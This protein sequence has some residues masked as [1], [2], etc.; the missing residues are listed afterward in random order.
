M[1]FSFN[2]NDPGR[3][4]DVNYFFGLGFGLTYAS[5]RN[6]ADYTRQARPA[7]Q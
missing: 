3:I 2:K 6:L 4:R 1:P 5:I 7:S